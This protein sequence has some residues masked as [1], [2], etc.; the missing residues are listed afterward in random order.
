[1]G[2]RRGRVNIHAITRAVRVWGEMG[3]SPKN[4]EDAMGVK[5]PL[6]RW[7]GVFICLTYRR[8]SRISICGTWPPQYQIYCYPRNIWKVSNIVRD[9]RT[10]A[11]KDCYCPSTTDGHRVSLIAGPTTADLRSIGQ[12]WM[13]H[14]PNPNPNPNANITL[15]SGLWSANRLSQDIGG[16]NHIPLLSVEIRREI[17]YYRAKCPSGPGGK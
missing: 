8:L 3:V 11:A 13:W 5:E 2:E 4:L 7:A 9:R 16:H 1:M 17:A 12:W 15:S 10:Y 6:F 14:N